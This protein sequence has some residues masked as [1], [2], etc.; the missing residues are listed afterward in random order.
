MQVKKLK[1]TTTISHKVYN[2]GLSPFVNTPKAKVENIFLLLYLKNSLWSFFQLIRNLIA[3][4]H[5]Q[6]FYISNTSVMCKPQR[7]NEPT[8]ERALGIKLNTQISKLKEII[9]I[10]PLGQLSCN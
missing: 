10:T 7:K 9:R 4:L 6:N 1:K 5:W 8:T 3:L 2:K